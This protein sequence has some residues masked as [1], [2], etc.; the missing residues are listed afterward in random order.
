M[1]GLIVAA[2]AGIAVWLQSVLVLFGPRD[3]RFDLMTLE[4]PEEESKGVE[5]KER[6]VLSE[7][8][9]SEEMREEI[10]DGVR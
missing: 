4:W 5:G 3:L 6:L 9:L 8:D 7:E 10:R 2:L 1:F